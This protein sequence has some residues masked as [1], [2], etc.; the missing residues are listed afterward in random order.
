VSA[1][2]RLVTET[3]TTATPDTALRPTSFS[4]YVGQAEVVDSLRD[5]VRAARRGHWQLDHVL[6]TGP[7]GLGKSSLAAIVASELGARVHVTSAPAIEHKGQL[8]SLLTTLGEGD[9]LFID[10]IHALD[11]AVAECLYLAMEDHVLD[12]PAGKRVIRVPL[13]R[14]T[15]IGATTHPG[16]LPAPLRDRFGLICQLRPYNTFELQLIVA[17]SAQLLGI[18]IDADGCTV[19]AAASRGTPRLANRLVRR[20]RD[21]AVNAAADGALVPRNHL[22]LRGGSCTVNGPLAAA[23][24]RKIGVDAIGLTDLDR[25]YLTA[26]TDHPVGIEAL[27]AQLG[28]ARQTIEESVEP[29]LLQAGLIARAARGRFATE[30]GRKH[31][32]C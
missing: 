19:I 17:R 1:A 21:V 14:F 2:L 30:A 13:P 15:L 10:E 29:F 23:A 3:P 32:A 22:N 16:K 25:R 7:A 26:V 6:M 12:M 11:R 9:V 28:E 18:A 24:L 31:L 4:D 8:A 27:T 20:V 5:A